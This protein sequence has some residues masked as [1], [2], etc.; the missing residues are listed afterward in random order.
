MA[1]PQEAKVPAERGRARKG[2]GSGGT[3][4]GGTHADD[5]IVSA[6]KDTT[7][8]AQA[9]RD[10]ALVAIFN[11][12]AADLQDADGFEGV[13]ADLLRTFTESCFSCTICDLLRNGSLLDVGHR[14]A[15]YTSL[16]DLLATL[17]RHSLLTPL[18]GTSPSD[19]AS[20]LQL[21]GALDQQSRIFFRSIP[22]TSQE[23]EAFLQ[24]ARTIHNVYEMVAESLLSEPTERGGHAFTYPAHAAAADLQAQ[25]V[26]LFRED[27]FQQ[28][29]LQQKARHHYSQAAQAATPV[30]RGVRQRMA[31]LA[32]LSGNLPCNWD[33]S[34]AVRV[35]EAN[36]SLLKV[37]IVGPTDTPYANG[38]FIFDV[39]LPPTYPAEPP[40]VHL[41]TTHPTTR[42]NPN[43]YAD[44]T[45]CLS[46][47][48]TW[49]GPGWVADT[50]TILQVL[51]SIHALIFVPDPYFN[52]PG[53]EVRKGTAAGD[54]A[55]MEYNQRIRTYTAKLAILEQLR[56]PSPC[57]AP[58]IKR[59]F[60][61]KREELTQ[62]LEAW[63][64]DM[65]EHSFGAK[66]KVEHWRP[67]ELSAAIK[68]E[69][70]KLRAAG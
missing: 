54:L 59:H 47:L 46:L 35:D 9:R 12:I 2:D 32:A 57:F 3:G 28:V 11:A 24:I 39:F 65:A 41:M 27:C 4:F 26:A 53:Y 60:A 22:Q 14:A 42:F 30:R 13:D 5:Q 58:L 52:E 51:V 49:A 34:I 67:G 37:M 66:G 8:S 69:L 55:T 38:C 1:P 25:Y 63:V 10:K 23:E 16:L 70:A 31:E 43:L 33:G 6:I 61:L 20:F 68:A 56:D 29:D 40:K 62:Q 17:K 19:T 45:V 44:G 64:T 50:S 36:S 15:L 48:G 7:S 18:L 21:L